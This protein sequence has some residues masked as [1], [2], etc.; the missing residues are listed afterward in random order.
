MSGKVV[1]E[2]QD[3]WQ[4]VRFGRISTKPFRAAMLRT[5]AHLRCAA[6]LSGLA[7]LG[8][9]AWAVSMG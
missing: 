9:A 4:L 1:E 7:L 3:Y 8:R 5:K 2:Q 6:G